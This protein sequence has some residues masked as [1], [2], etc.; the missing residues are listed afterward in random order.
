MAVETV[1]CLGQSRAAPAQIWAIA[2]RF[3]DPW[4]PMIASMQAEAGGAI[5]AFSVAGETTL[6]REQLT[7]L[8]DTDHRLAYRH[9][10][11]IA[12]AR[13]YRAELLLE[14]V[15]GGGTSLSWKAEIEAD[16]PR[17]QEIAQG[18]R[19]VFEAGLAALADLAEQKKALKAE[20][21]RRAHQ[22]QER[23][24]PEERAGRAAGGRAPADQAAG[25]ASHSAEAGPHLRSAAQRRSLKHPA[26]CF[27]GWGSG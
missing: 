22:G 19:L 17:A 10:E 20:G 23:T 3:C 11:G 13:S 8:S 25:G 14:P 2:R 5:R 27:R 1:T 16:L 26:P 4:H 9:L 18:T 15:D 21:G 6:Y 24:G 12:G 7:Y